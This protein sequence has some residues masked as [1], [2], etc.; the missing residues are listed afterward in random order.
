GSNQIRLTNNSEYDYNPV[1]SPD[2]SKIAFES[3]RDGN[4]EIYV[5]DA[6]GSNQVN[7]TNNI[8]DD[9]ILLMISDQ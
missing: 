9:G 6:N 1:W 7:L 3:Y 5:M 4:R 2:G 8:A